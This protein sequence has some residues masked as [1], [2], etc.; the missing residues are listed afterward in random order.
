[1]L[2]DTHA[3]INFRAYKEDAKETIDRALL[4]DTWVVNIGSQI[5]TSRQAV[6]LANQFEKGVYAVVG[7][8]PEHTHSQF[9]DEEETHFQTREETF[10]YDMYKKLAQDPKV[11]GI[12]E[13]G[14]DYYRLSSQED[15]PLVGE[16]K[17]K[18]KDAFRAQVKLALELNKSLVVHSRPAKHNEELFDDILAILDEQFFYRRHSE[19]V[20]P[21][22]ESQT[23]AKILHPSDALGVQDYASLRFVLHSFTGSPTALQKFLDRGAFVSFNGIITF[24]KT[25]NMEKLVQMVPMEKLLLE[26]DCPYLTPVPFR[27]KRNEPAYVSYVAQKVAENKGLA[28]ETVAEIT[29]NNAKD[30]FKLIN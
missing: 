28:I 2:V 16:I 11:V 5:D 25:G 20:Q 30:F 12:G 9:V 1:M 23:G 10:D 13:C 29:S 21:T 27:G 7:L 17:N 18:Q 19:G 4:E 15:D 3:H 22:E 26:T 14:L 24:D 8:H 6:E